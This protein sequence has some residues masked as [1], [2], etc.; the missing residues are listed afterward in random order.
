MKAL[1]AVPVLAS[2]FLSFQVSAGCWSITDTYT[3]ILQEGIEITA[4][5][6]F[7]ITS[8]NGCFGANI[9]ATISAV[10]RGRPPQ[11][12]I[13]REVGSSWQQVAGNTGSNVL[14]SGSFGTYRVRLKNPD[15]AP[16]V[17]LGTVKYGR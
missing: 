4:Y 2:V 11:L 15:A 6:P 13:E 10:D 1:F 5:G 16:K 3:G 8:A 7:T 17:Y 14:F 12:S 9:D